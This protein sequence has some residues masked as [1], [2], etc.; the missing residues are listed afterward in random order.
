MVLRY[1]K[2]AT[3]HGDLSRKHSEPA[4]IVAALRLLGLRRARSSE[5]AENGKI[6][7]LGFPPPALRSGEVVNPRGRSLPFPARREML[8]SNLLSP[9]AALRAR[10]SLNGP[11]KHVMSQVGFALGVLTS[12]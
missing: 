6:M 7:I 11:A 4:T 12:S 8:L 1:H 9:C 2:G 10:L 5:T 3:R